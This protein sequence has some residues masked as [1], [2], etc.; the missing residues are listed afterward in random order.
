MRVFLILAILLGFPV[1]EI[2]TL[3]RLADVV[4]WWLLPWLLFAALAGWGLLR[5]AGFAAPARL[6]LAL[7]SGQSLGASLWFGLMP[8]VA[9]IL[10]IFPGVISDVIALLLLLF[11]QPIRNK[12]PHPPEDGVI[13]GEWRKVEER[14]ER[15]ELEARD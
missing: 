8:F 3:V 6:L 1:L 10:L 13:E 7:R 11:S 14:R 15:I 5:E 4:G 2:F 9:G 12:T